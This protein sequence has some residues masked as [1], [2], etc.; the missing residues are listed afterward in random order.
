MGLFDRI[1]SVV[2]AEWHSRFGE[3]DD[4]G[5]KGRHAP[6]GSRAAPTPGAR[7]R[8]ITDTDSAYRVL[9]LVPSATLDEVR[10]AYREMARRYHPRTYSK[11]PDQAHA[12]ETLLEALT[13]AL[14]VL[15]E[16][17]LPLPSGR[18]T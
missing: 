1:S 13:D 14:E 4:E 18:R 5:A 3:H 10:A 2:K 12:A 8:S 11:V 9:E 17:L 7:R 15:E 6:R 16:H